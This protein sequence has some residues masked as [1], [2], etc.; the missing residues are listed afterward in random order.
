MFDNLSLK[1]M[2]DGGVHLY[3]KVV[4][5]QDNVFATDSVDCQ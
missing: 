5:L 1:Q 4:A 3:D 2:F